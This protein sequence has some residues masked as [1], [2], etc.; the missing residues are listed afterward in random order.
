MPGACKETKVLEST[1]PHRLG[2]TASTER[3]ALIDEPLEVRVKTLPSR[4]TIFLCKFRPV[5]GEWL[6]QVLTAA[7]VTP[8][9]DVFSRGIRADWELFQ[10]AHREQEQIDNG[11]FNPNVSE[12]SYVDLLKRHTSDPSIG[13]SMKEFGADYVDLW[14]RALDDNNLALQKAFKPL[15]IVDGRHFPEAYIR[16]NEDSHRRESIGG[17]FYHNNPDYN[18]IR[19][20]RHS[21]PQFRGGMYSEFGRKEF[22]AF[23]D[24]LKTTFP[25]KDRLRSAVYPHIVRWRETDLIDLFP[26]GRDYYGNLVNVHNGNDGSHSWISE[27]NQWPNYTFTDEKIVLY[28]GDSQATIYLEQADDPAR[29]FKIT[30]RQVSFTNTTNAISPAISWYQSVD[31]DNGTVRRKLLNRDQVNNRFAEEF[32]GEVLDPWLGLIAMV[33]FMPTVRAHTH[34]R[35][36]LKDEGEEVRRRGGQDINAAQIPVY[37][38]RPNKRKQIT[39]DP[40]GVL[41]SIEGM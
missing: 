33:G 22:Y 13:K 14:V 1:T 38:N 15:I 27:F 41:A 7:T 2:W 5:K 8:E 6:G 29:P 35:L 18:L 36:H 24:W 17:E 21:V 34:S 12:F 9:R 32:P 39:V 10:D 25:D 40:D 23:I 20:F 16:E 26:F 3:T 11:E 28:G 4:G 37:W 30:G 19:K 31:S